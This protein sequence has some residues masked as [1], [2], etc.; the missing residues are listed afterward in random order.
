ME[1]LE[2]LQAGS[3]A[4]PVMLFP[5]YRALL[6]LRAAERVDPA[7]LYFPDLGI[8]QPSELLGQGDSA[9]GN[10]IG[11][12][13]ASA[14]REFERGLLGFLRGDDNV[15][16]L[17]TMHAAMTRMQISN[18]VRHA[19]TFFWISLA[20]LDA[21]KH[22]A[23]PVDLYTKRLVARV[24][25]QARRTLE[26]QDPVA[27][28][29]LKDILFAL[30]RAKDLS[31]VIAEVRRQYRLAGTVPVDF[32]QVR[33]GLADPT[34]MAAASEAV[35][36]LRKSWEKVVRGTAKEQEVFAGGAASLALS[37]RSLPY[38]GMNE[39]A[40][41]LVGVSSALTSGAALDD[42]LSLEVATAILFAEEA[43]DG[44]LRADPAYDTSAAR[45]GSRVRDVIDRSASFSKDTPHWLVEVSRKASA[46]SVLAALVTELKANLRGCEQAL[47]KYFRN[48]ATALAAEALASLL[49]QARAVLTTLG[50]V[51]AAKACA[52]LEKD[53]RAL[54][55]E[56]DQQGG[57]HQRIAD[58]LSALGFFFDS[59]LQPGAQSAA[60]RFDELERCFRLIA[61][62]PASDQ[63]GEGA[64]PDLAITGVGVDASPYEVGSAESR[65][66]AERNALVPWLN[67]LTTVPQAADVHDNLQRCLMALERDL[68]LVDEVELKRKTAEAL[69]LL[70]DVMGDVGSGRG[71]EWPP[72]ASEARGAPGALIVL[73][74][75][76]AGVK[77]PEAVD[78]GQTQLVDALAL[79]GRA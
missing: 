79:G 2:D 53:V 36:A 38:K 46:R 21:L 74:A 73:L 54:S 25:I 65:I 8:Q 42:T 11:M 45:L 29:L 63:S 30:A 76:I 31:P 55:H 14:R 35:R 66:D 72:A 62:D 60:F 77:P 33:Y 69:K 24:N 6:L 40:D 47:D 49:E 39:L 41:S 7:D 78:L 15:S 12:L 51:E 75:Q 27:D 26:N 48:P 23:L 59:L 18:P 16:S 1:Y 32:E 44:G 68:V 71:A 10:D 17:R 50:Y 61:N 57:D 20:L 28:R 9:D 19:R 67:L 22:D 13:A 3:T 56:S 64:T 37:L 70:G 58:N 52:C 34:L 5:I 43:L 4:P